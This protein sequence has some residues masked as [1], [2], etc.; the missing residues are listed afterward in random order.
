MNNLERFKVIQKIF[1]IIIISILFASFLFERGTAM[2]DVLN[3]AV[4]IILPTYLIFQFVYLYKI[5][6]E[7]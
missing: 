4:R 5:R 2:R 6:D 1:R 3:N 7:L